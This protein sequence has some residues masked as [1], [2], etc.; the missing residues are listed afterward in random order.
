MASSKDRWAHNRFNCFA[1]L[2]TALQEAEF[3]RA[4]FD[5]RTPKGASTVARHH[6]C[7]I[8]RDL[9]KVAVLQDELTKLHEDMVCHLAM[10]AKV[11]MIQRAL[12]TAIANPHCEL[13]R[14]RLAREFK[15]LGYVSS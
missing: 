1:K 7:R 3:W 11:R 5:T 9:Q 15:E 8:D 12:R 2:D 13:G 10:E 4:W 14:R 6:L